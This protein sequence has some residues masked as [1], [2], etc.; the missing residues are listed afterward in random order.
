VVCY[1]KKLEQVGDMSEMCVG[2]SNKEKEDVDRGVKVSSG[3][4]EPWKWIPSP[5]KGSAN[6]PKGLEDS[7]ILRVL[8]R[9]PPTFPQGVHERFP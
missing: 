1:F 7:L 8:H 6:R 5:N 3:R 9:M 2:S 4:W